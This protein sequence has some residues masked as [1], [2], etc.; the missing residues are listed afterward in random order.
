MS[1]TKLIDAA[2]R[3]VAAKR[4]LLDE[5]HPLTKST[6]EQWFEEMISCAERGDGA[7]VS[8]LAAQIDAKI[9]DAHD[10]LVLELTT[11]DRWRR[12]LLRH[13]IGEMRSV[14]RGIY[15]GPT[16]PETEDL[17]QCAIDLTEAGRFAR[18]EEVCAR[19]EAALIAERRQ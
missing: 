16:T 3:F 10:P 7:E 15:Y 12:D 5:L 11:A 13:R 14:K 4:A 18:A 19:A 6:I 17:V 2:V 8:Y 9:E 1:R